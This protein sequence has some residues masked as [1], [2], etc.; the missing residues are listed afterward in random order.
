M[1]IN[2]IPDG[3]RDF[4]KAGHMENTP[5]NSF[6]V[7]QPVILKVIFAPAG[8]CLCPCTAGADAAA[9]AIVLHRPTRSRITTGTQQIASG[10]TRDIGTALVIGV[11]HQPGI[12]HLFAITVAY[13]QDH[14]ALVKGN[15]GQH[16]LWIG[17]T[18]AF[19]GNKGG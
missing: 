16:R 14:V 1:N 12:P 19:V 5:L 9:L 6:R 11:E 15:A 4:W 17:K 10:A 3:R 2:R 13:A 7:P 18:R 8:A